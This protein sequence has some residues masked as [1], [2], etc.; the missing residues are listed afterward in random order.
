MPILTS[1]YSGISG[2]SANG[3]ALSVIG[4]NIANVNT[5][6]Y[7]ASRASFAD[8]L[9][10]SVEGGSGKTQVGRGVYLS[11]VSQIFTQ[12]SLEA[13]ANGLDFGIDGSG[14][15][16]LKDTSGT[17]F[18]SR[19]GQFH[20]SKDGLVV[21]SDGLHLQGYQADSAG[22]V[23][24]TIED[25]DISSNSTSPR[26]TSGIEITSNLDSRVSP[27]AAGFD[28]N[29]TSG[30]S[31]FSTSLSVYDSLG[32]DH[33]VSTYFTKV[34]ED[35]AGQTG[36]YWQWNAVSDGA[37]GPEVMGTGYLQFD[38]TGALVSDQVA[39]MDITLTDAP[40]VTNPTG[41]DFP[42]PI[43]S[44]NFTGGV[45]QNQSISFSFGTGTA[46]G[47]S[48][49]DGTTQFG[50]LSS[51]LFQSQDGYGSGSLQSLSIN[52]GG[53]IS[54]LYT[55]G[56]ARVLGQVVLGMFNDT[57]GLLKMGRNLYAESFDS[58]QVILGAPDSG[59]RGKLLSSSLE[60]S[61]VDLAE[62]FVK[63]ITVQRGF[64]AN[65]RIIT[66]TDEMLNELVS[67]KR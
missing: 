45:S 63:L 51:T 29:D 40:G 6:G 27:V 56:Q 21:N 55:N 2:L 13:T 4:N 32:N 64:Q 25:I 23:S 42:D 44:F 57:Q 38:S 3:A 47:G 37:S 19:A 8:V 46:N 17:P 60:L 62:E 58:G 35:T 33:I 53:M 30:T 31:N 22:D 59:G 41:V 20:V 65:S 48:G 9:N 36:N 24:G 1:L 39:D 15:F 10:Q 67:L 43:S 54:G 18:Y 34:Y 12:G 49:M 16:L 11:D 5:V 28:I 7:K 52:Q 26:T 50:A 14:F 66:T 61:N